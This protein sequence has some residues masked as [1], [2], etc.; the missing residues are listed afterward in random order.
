[1][2]LPQ[3]IV[4]RSFFDRCMFWIMTGKKIMLSRHAESTLSCCGMR[5]KGCIVLRAEKTEAPEV[6]YCV[7]KRFR[8][9]LECFTVF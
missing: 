9:C 4:E 1:M 7:L 3:N 8:Y 2:K 5:R 6:F